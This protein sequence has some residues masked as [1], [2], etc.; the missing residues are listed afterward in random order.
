M[1]GDFHPRL[2]TLLPVPGGL[3]EGRRDVD[4]LN[5]GERSLDVKCLLVEP[6]EVTFVRPVRA[7]VA[8]RIYLYIYM[9]VGESESEILRASYLVARSKKSFCHPA[10]AS[11]TCSLMLVG[12]TTASLV[13]SSL[14]SLSLTFFRWVFGTPAVIVGLRRVAAN[15][16][17]VPVPADD[18]NVSLRTM[19]RF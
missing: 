17:I 8:T 13:S 5:Q 6:L 18:H 19:P 11:I 9:M 2:A 4:L 10:S 7:E 16:R 14:I 3:A 15:M 1:H 12:S